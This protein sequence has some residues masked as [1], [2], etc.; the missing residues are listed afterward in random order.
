MY[1]PF[2]ES[3]SPAVLDVE[4]DER[5]DVDVVRRSSARSKRHEGDVDADHPLVEE[6]RR[7]PGGAT[8]TC[9]ARAWPPARVRVE[10]VEHDLAALVAELE[11]REAAAR[12]R[13][14]PRSGA[15][16]RPARGR[17]PRDVVSPLASTTRAERS[18]DQLVPGASSSSNVTSAPAPDASWRYARRRP[19]SGP[20][21]STGRP[22]AS[23][24]DRRAA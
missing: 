10:G 16:S 6:V 21:P 22:A 9:P 4:R 17:R 14:A 18:R 11:L 24:R 7:D 13:R 2:A 15:R 19:R 12:S 8:C 23:T 20:P 3:P 5:R 1:R